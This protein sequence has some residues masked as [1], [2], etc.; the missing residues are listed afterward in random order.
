MI[1]PM[2]DFQI[3]GMTP[4]YMLICQGGFQAEVVDNGR[5]LDCPLVLATS[6]KDQPGLTGVATGPLPEGGTTIHG[7]RVIQ[8]DIPPFLVG[9]AGRTRLG[10]TFVLQPVALA[11]LSP[12]KKP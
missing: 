10:I 3:G 7:S 5:V 9:M 11:P 12:T 2:A 8:A 4:G 1:A 6:E